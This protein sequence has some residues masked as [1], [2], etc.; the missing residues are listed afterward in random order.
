MRSLKKMRKEENLM[1]E[2][3]DDGEARIEGS[4]EHECEKAFGNV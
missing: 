4:N 1:Y 3:R 2:E